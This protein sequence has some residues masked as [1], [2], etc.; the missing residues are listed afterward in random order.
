M[1]ANTCV[2]GRD[3]PNHNGRNHVKEDIR[4]RGKCAP[5]TA[6]DAGNNVSLRSQRP[7]KS[8][9]G[10]WKRENDEGLNGNTPALLFDGEGIHPQ[11][12]DLLREVSHNGQ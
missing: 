7:C 11:K 9:H 5:Y 8:H 4:P 2:E 6:F 3:Q 12:A 10:D 1:N